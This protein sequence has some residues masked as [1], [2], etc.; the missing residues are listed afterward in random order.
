MTTSTALADLV[1][2]VHAITGLA[3]FGGLV[4]AIA[5]QFLGWRWIF[6]LNWRLPHLALT[7]YL[8]FRARCGFACPLSVLEDALRSSDNRLPSHMDVGH[9]MLRL[10]A[11]RNLDASSFNTAILAFATITVSLFIAQRC[12]ERS[13]NQTSKVP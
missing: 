3:V 7:L 8:V 12:Y 2:M 11:F 6:A 4:M 10:L 1:L 9:E 5:G 13:L